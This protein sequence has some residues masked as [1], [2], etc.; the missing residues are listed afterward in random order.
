MPEVPPIPPAGR[1][2][3]VLFADDDRK[4][5]DIV[6]F[7]LEKEGFDVRTAPDGDAAVKA[8]V[9]D[10]PD[11]IVLDVNMPW[12][13][14]FEACGELKKVEKTKNIPVIFLTAEKGDQSITKARYR[15]AVAY[16][17]KPFR[18]DALV[19]LVREVM[20]LKR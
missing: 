12:K 4:I 1:K 13:D 17:E 16:L 18:N 3:T 9:D 2:P 11:V 20:K 19:A 10:P 8:A 6:Q 7:V 14:G 5:R 15:G